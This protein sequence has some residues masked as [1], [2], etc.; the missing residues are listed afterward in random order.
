MKF[1]LMIILL[2]VS[3]PL[4]GFSHRFSFINC[5]PKSNEN[6]NRNG[7]LG[8]IT[9]GPRQWDYLT[10]YNGM[11]DGNPSNAS[12]ASGG[13]QN[14]DGF[15]FQLNFNRSIALKMM[16]LNGYA[17]SSYPTNYLIEY[18]N[19]SS[20]ITSKVISHIESSQ[21]R[22]VFYFNNNEE[23][24]SSNWRWSIINWGY[25]HTNFY[26]YEVEAYEKSC[27]FLW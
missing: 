19:G 13:A 20:W 16:V 12:L 22:G 14:H 9:S 18:Y 10:N 23:I 21:K 8:S 6:L 17:S 2:L 4:F 15:G 25:A 3:F 24:K 1:L 5:K 7:S 27:S 11:I 26:L